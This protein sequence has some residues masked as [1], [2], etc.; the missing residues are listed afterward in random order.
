M[1]VSQEIKRSQ[2]YQSLY[3]DRLMLAAFGTLTPDI[4]TRSSYFFNLWMKRRPYRYF[5]QKE[6][7]RLAHA[8]LK[9]LNIKEQWDY[10]FQGNEIRFEHAED[11][12]Q[13]KILW[14]NN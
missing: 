1:T 9:L 11:L 12:A 8:T 2:T 3:P 13:F 10:Q 4:A 7:I 5:V 6:K 14:G